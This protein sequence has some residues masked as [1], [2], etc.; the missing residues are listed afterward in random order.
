MNRLSKFFHCQN[1]K[2]ISNKTIATDLT[3]PKACRYITLWNV[4]VLRITIKNKMTFV[5]TQFFKINNRHVF[6]VSVII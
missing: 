2:T 6:F 1:Q 5:T 3:T 4:S